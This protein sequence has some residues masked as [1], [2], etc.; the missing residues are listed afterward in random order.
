MKARLK[1]WLWL[2]WYA[3]LAALGAYGVWLN[4]YLYFHRDIFKKANG[5]LT[6]SLVIVYLLLFTFAAKKITKRVYG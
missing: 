6:P 1:R 2:T 4:L 5:W 3:N